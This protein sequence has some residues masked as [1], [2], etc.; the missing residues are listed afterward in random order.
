MTPLTSRKNYKQELLK[1]GYIRDPLIEVC[2][3]TLPCESAVHLYKKKCVLC[4][5]DSHC[6]AFGCLVWCTLIC[7]LW[8]LCLLYMLYLLCLLCLKYGVFF[9]AWPCISACSYIFKLLFI[10]NLIIDLLLFIKYYLLIVVIT[11]HLSCTLLFT[12]WTSFS[13]VI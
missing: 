5:W 4:F 3:Q 8:L 10:N 6:R 13:A 7:L 2:F 11:F 1:A 9:G 12:L